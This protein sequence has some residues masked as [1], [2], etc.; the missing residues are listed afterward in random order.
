M[1]K[2]AYTKIVFLLSPYSLVIQGNISNPNQFGPIPLYKSSLRKWFL[3]HKNTQFIRQSQ[4]L[5]LSRPYKLMYSH[6]CRKEGRPLS[7]EWSLNGCCLL[8][9]VSH[10][11]STSLSIFPSPHLFPFPSLSSSSISLLFLLFHFCASQAGYS[12]LTES[13]LPDQDLFSPYQI[14]SFLI[15]SIYSILNLIL[16]K[17]FYLFHCK[18]LL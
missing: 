8:S 6:G 15:N 11:L 18:V 5:S 4:L 10:P 12:F 17:Q 13:S 16:G 14:E 3:L 9:A 7:L 2:F 1:F